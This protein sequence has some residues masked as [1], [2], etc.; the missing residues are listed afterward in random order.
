MFFFEKKNQKTFVCLALSDAGLPR[1]VGWASPHHRS[2]VQ[3]RR[4]FLSRL[5]YP[6]LTPI[7]VLTDQQPA[8]VVRSGK[9]T[10]NNILLL[11]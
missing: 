11:R 8:S 10:A 6:A 3:R 4:C 1:D 2:P 5:P 7:R 9:T